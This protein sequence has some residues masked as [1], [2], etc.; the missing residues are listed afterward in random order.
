MSIEAVQ[1]VR[2]IDSNKDAVEM[3]EDVSGSRT[4]KKSDEEGR[5]QEHVERTPEDANLER[6]LLLKA[7]L[8]ILPLIFVAYLLDFLVCTATSVI[9]KII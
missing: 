2:R 5:V 4:L 1:P 7:D 9:T 6:R 8:I 3:L